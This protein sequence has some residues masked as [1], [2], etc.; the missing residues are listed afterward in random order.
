M[1]DRMDARSMF[2]QDL[3]RIFLS[4]V[5]SC[6]QRSPTVLKVDYVKSSNMRIYRL[7]SPLTSNVYACVWSDTSSH[8]FFPS[9]IHCWLI[10]SSHLFYALYWLIH[11]TGSSS[12]QV[13]LD[14]FSHFRRRI[15]SMAD[16]WRRN[17]WCTHPY[18]KS[19]NCVCTNSRCTRSLKMIHIIV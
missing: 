9:Q 5:R 6:H 2:Y 18:M 16:N 3:A 17:K 1:I 19:A 7:K 14:T 15:L 11:F 8:H 13:K 12:F 10:W 4:P